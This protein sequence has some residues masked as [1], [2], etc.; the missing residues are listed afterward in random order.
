MDN[1]D[2][3]NLIKNNKFEKIKELIINKK[4][5]DFDI[6]DENN[7]Y[8]IHYIINYNQYEILKLILN[9][10]IRLDILDIDGRTI[11]YT[12]IK[13]NYFKILELL[14]DY[15]KKTI[16]I[17]ILDIKDKF[18]LTALHY[19]IIY[20][21][22]NIFK[23]LL[24]NNADLFILS[25]DSNNSISYSIIYNRN[26]IFDYILEKN[27]NFHNFINNKGFNLLQIALI[28]KN[29]YVLKKLLDNNIN[30]NLNNKDYENGHTILHQS[31]I[32]DNIEIFEL[33]LYKNID[34]N[35]TDFLGNTVLHYIL[36]E[37]KYNYLDKLLKY[38][39]K[40]KYNISNI[41]GN[42][43]LHTLLNDYNYV[44]EE[45]L[46][47]FIINS[48]LNI[49]NNEGNTCLLM[50]YEKDLLIKYKE[51]L[52]NK[53]LNFYIENNNSK[54]INLNDEIINILIES[55]Y[56]QLIA[57]KDLLTIEW[58]KLCSNNDI[59]G[60]KK[61]LNSKSNDSI[62]L[63]KNH[64]KN[65]IINEKRT[66]PKFMKLKLKMDNGVMINNGYYTGMPIDIL[67]GII[68]LYKEFQNKGLSIILD[69]PL[70]INEEFEKYYQKLGLDYNYKI[71]F[72]NIEILW[73]YQKMFFPS[74]YEFEIKKLLNN[75]SYIIIPIGIEN[76]NGAHANIIFWDIKKKIIYRFEPNGSNYPSGLNY[77]P[78]ILDLLL[79]NKFKTFD[80]EIKYLKPDNYLPSIGFQ[81]LENLDNNNKKIG[82]PNG[83]CALWCIWWVYQK[84]NNLNIDNLEEELINHIKL[85]GTS[86][87]SIIRNFSINII[88]LRDKF[89]SKYKIDI[90][91][92]ITDNYNNEIMNNLEKDILNYI[93]Y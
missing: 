8:F 41:L 12:P 65:I 90:N 24:L 48:N 93:K 7:N 38:K 72:S 35:I 31:F 73:S 26:D 15:N 27:I 54:K 14:L 5:K 80:K 45:I 13:Y 20:N 33:L 29:I 36:N 62:L 49:Q 69:Y 77:N 22:M 18:G 57:N 60:L 59:N 32:Y 81:I 30:I 74:Y 78:K 6:I 2:I 70:T 53:E 42:I 75:S 17:S 71:D 47:I 52:V 25:N 23:L 58:E 83:F 82:D 91:D 37:K 56:N 19:S 16:G 43:P 76:S 46:K 50:L 87:K 68:Y 63:C 85:E 79:E 67:F 55:Y 84:M 10:D 44:D 28:N 61:L 88:N 64:I 1:N 86:F 11:L 4:I 39:D 89:L 51:I 92:W 40:I 3:F 34:I 9:Y 66:I 21:N